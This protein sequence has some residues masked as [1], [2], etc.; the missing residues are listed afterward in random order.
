MD[1]AK[2]IPIIR[3][4]CDG[5]YTPQE[6][7]A[8]VDVSQKI[9]IS[10][11]KYL[12]LNGKQIRPRRSKGI[13]EIEDVAIDCIAG[14]FM[15]NKQGEFVQL[16]R[17]FEDKNNIQGTISELQIN[18]MLRR[19][20]VKKTKQELSRIFKERDPEGAKIIRNIKVAIR[21]SDKYS[22]FKQ[23]GREFVFPLNKDAEIEADVTIDSISEIE[24]RIIPDKILLHH[25]LDKYL[26]SDPISIML[27]KIMDIVMSL[28]DYQKYA[29]LDLIANVIREVT[30]QHVKERLT[31][32][33]DMKSPIHDLQTEEIEKVNQDVIKD[34]QQ[35]IH[36][37]YLGRGKITPEK[38]NVYIQ[39][40]SAFIIEFTQDKTTDSNFQYLNRYLPT[41]TQKTYRE[42]ERSI[43]E[44]LVKVTKKTLRNKLKELL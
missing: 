3:H 2:L 12:E 41:L 40:I 44:Y 38:A 22:S 19:L 14:L 24:K 35:K 33:V 28:P 25:F 32:D 13:N 6:L 15:R 17:Y 37:Q 16:R 18:S 20:I 29:P 42:Q 21:N 30:F 5:S 36:H 26:P 4:I 23:M 11:L 27:D 43:F 10:Y 31:D 34:I 8:F 9:A 1:S 7:T 39:A